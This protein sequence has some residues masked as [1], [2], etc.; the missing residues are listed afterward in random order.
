MNGL[1]AID[2]TTCET[3]AV[4]TDD[5]ANIC[6]VS[7]STFAFSAYMIT[8][9]DSLGQEFCVFYLLAIINIVYKIFE[10][11]DW[12]CPQQNVEIIFE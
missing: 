9:T 8:T 6:S 2:G 4:W 5:T 1:T 12:I 7:V 3:K 10:D 11:N